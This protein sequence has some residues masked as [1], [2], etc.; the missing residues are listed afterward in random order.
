[1]MMP[2]LKLQVSV[3]FM[4]AILVAL[5]IVMQVGQNQ[6]FGHKSAQILMEHLSMVQAVTA[7]VLCLSM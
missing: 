4:P 1:M 3:L 5:A 7:L 2:C 6:L